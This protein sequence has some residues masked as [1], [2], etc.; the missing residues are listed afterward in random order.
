MF[1]LR[2][3][4]KWYWPPGKWFYGPTPLP[5][6][7]SWA[8][9]PP[10]PLEFP[11][12]SVVGVWIFSGTTHSN[13]R[14]QRLGHPFAW[15]INSFKR[16]C[17]LFVGNINPFE[18]LGHPF[19]EG[20][21]LNE[22][23]GHLF[24]EDVRPFE[25]LGHPYTI[26]ASLQ[27]FCWMTW[28]TSNAICSKYF[29]CSSG[30]L[31]QCLKNLF[32]FIGTS[33]SALNSFLALLK[34]LAYTSDRFLIRRKIEAKDILCKQTF[35]KK[36]SK[37]FCFPHVRQFFAHGSTNQQRKEI[38]WVITRTSDSSSCARAGPGV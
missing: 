31:I 22:R 2:S 6:G 29:T 15:N 1:E 30:Q 14:T 8:S 38:L 21:R 36:P 12:P 35:Q 4:T 7:I 11:I 37:H 18:L 25:R 16:L 26:M 13:K 5:S 32:D 9:D 19:V 24:V 34:Q 27:I 28:K 33:L 17:H 23:P 10:T 20:I 3:K